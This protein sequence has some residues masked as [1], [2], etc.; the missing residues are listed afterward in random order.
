MQIQEDNVIQTLG[1][2]VCLLGVGAVCVLLGAGYL[3]F[4]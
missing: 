4:K 3:L 2:L 1:G